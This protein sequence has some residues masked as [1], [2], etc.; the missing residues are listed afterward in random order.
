MLIKMWTSEHVHTIVGAC[1]SDVFEWDLW[2][3]YV[4]VIMYRHTC[5]FVYRHIQWD[6]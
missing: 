2:A 5:M 6:E 4:T 1:I 3:H